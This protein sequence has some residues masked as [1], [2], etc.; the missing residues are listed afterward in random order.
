MK[1]TKKT[2]NGRGVEIALQGNGVVLYALLDSYVRPSY[3]RRTKTTPPSNSMAEFADAKR[4]GMK[5]KKRRSRKMRHLPK[6]NN[7]S[8]AFAGQEIQQ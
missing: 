7:T 3:R 5:T 4:M 6:F 2:M 1:Q 8:Y